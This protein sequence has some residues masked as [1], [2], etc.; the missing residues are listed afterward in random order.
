[1]EVISSVQF[2]PAKD[3]ETVKTGYLDVINNTPGIEKYA[4]WSYGKHPTDDMLRSYIDNGEMYILIENGRTAGMAAI[5]MCQDQD[6]EVIQW[7]ESLMNDEVATLHLLAVCPEFQGRAL[8]GFILD[9]AIEL[10]GRNGKKTL[11][12]DVLESNLPAQHMYEKSGFLYR[13]KQ[14]LYAENTGWTNFLYYEKPL[15]ERKT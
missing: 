14:C 10:V 3:F 5:V 11:R 9:Q 2:I 13:G 7:T 1:M 6:Y 4:R 12:L 8:G 15:N